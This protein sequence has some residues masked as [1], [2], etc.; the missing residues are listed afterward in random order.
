MRLPLFQAEVV[1][2]WVISKT[3]YLVSL[4]HADVCYS[5]QFSSIFVCIMKFV[6]DLL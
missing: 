6:S 4:D 3:V 2:F 1:A 5:V